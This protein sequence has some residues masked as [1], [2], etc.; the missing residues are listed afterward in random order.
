MQRSPS[1]RSS[2]PSAGRARR[3]RTFGAA[4][5]AAAAALL[6]FGR[7]RRNLAVR[8]ID[9]ERRAV[10][11][12]AIGH[13]ELVV[14]AGGRV[15]RGLVEL[16]LLLRVERQLDEVCRRSRRRPGRRTAT[17]SSFSSS[18]SASVSRL[19]LP[20]RRP[21]HRRH[22]VV[23]PDAL[24]IGLCRPPCAGPYMTDPRRTSRRQLRRRLRKD[25]H[26][27]QSECN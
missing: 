22:A 17:T 21:R 12:L 5:A 1:G 9:D 3:L 10:V 18:T 16:A 20:L 13:P 23:R 11:P 7:Q 19:V 27:R 4:A 2:G 26:R 15:V 24:Q 8:R 25:R 6:A 14:V